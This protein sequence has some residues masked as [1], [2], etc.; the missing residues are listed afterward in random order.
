MFAALE[1]LQNHYFQTY[2]RTL[3][4][5]TQSIHLSNLNIALLCRDTQCTTIL[6]SRVK[7]F[8]QRTGCYVESKHLDCIK[9]WTAFVQSG[10]SLI[11]YHFLLKNRI[12]CFCKVTCRFIS[13]AVML[14]GFLIVFQRDIIKRNLFLASNRCARNGGVE[15]STPHTCNTWG[16][17]CM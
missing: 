15:H 2:T 7:A 9:K 1:Y 12:L 3:L 13:I 10:A 4:K 11:C 16:G 5:Y 6:F 14:L 17:R 8:S